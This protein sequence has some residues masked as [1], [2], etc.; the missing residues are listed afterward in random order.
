MG[1]WLTPEIRAQHKRFFELRKQT[2]HN[3][4]ALNTAALELYPSGSVNWH[5]YR[6]LRGDGILEI[7]GTHSFKNSVM[8]GVV[9]QIKEHFPGVDITFRD[10]IW[11]GQNLWGVE[12]CLL[13]CTN[14]QVVEIMKIL[15]TIISYEQ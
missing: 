3:I 13:L 15:P 11:Y 14:E 1:S 4:V 10:D 8:P 5:T 12:I 9:R 6:P 2:R 7:Y